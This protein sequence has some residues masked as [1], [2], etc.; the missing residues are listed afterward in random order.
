M[1]QVRSEHDEKVKE[2]NIAHE[3]EIAALRASMGAASSEEIE[4][5]KAKHAEEM[6]DQ[7]RQHDEHVAQLNANFDS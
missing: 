4:R 6:K 5:L 2:I 1:R 7:G 3:N